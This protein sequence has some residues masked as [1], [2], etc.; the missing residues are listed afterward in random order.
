MVRESAG[1]HYVRGRTVRY[2]TG[3]AESPPDAGVPE[4]VRSY[5]SLDCACV[6][7]LPDPKCALMIARLRKLV[8]FCAVGLTCLTLSVAVLTGLDELAGVNYLVAYVASFLVS[9]L[10]GYLLNARFTFSSKSVDHAGAIRY[11]TVN[12][13]LLAANTLCMKLLVDAL[14]MWYLAAAILMSCFNMPLSFLGQW[15]FTYRPQARDRPAAV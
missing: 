15:R 13:I 1:P 7:R 2:V 14:H 3:L 11:M 8:R 6:V 9:N 12:A 4:R 10:A 5:R